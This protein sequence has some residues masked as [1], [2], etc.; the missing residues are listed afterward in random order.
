MEPEQ[1]QEK[2]GGGVLKASEQRW[3]L[4]SQQMPLALIEW[5]PTLHVLDWNPAA[6]R[7][8]G[9][10][11]A[12]TLGQAA[13]EF[14]VPE[15]AR[16]HV[17]NVGRNLLEQK[18]PVRSINENLTKDGRILICDWYNTPLIDASGQ[19]VGLNSLVLD[20]TERVQAKR[21][22]SESEERHRMT[23][24]SSPDPIVIY[25]MEGRAEYV[26]PA[27]VQTFG[28]D[29]TELLGKRIAFVPPQAT[30]ETLKE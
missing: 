13:L 12:E 23:L 3:T 4:L 9:F 6:E 7:L 24:E 10:T 30:D 25:D 17:R 16:E 21:A 22:L 19:I 1:F 8:F 26:N 27:F 28:W 18:R 29:E 5:D 11:K 2:P 15:N 14:L 20:I